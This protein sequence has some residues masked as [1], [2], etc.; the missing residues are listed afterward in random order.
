MTGCSQAPEDRCLPVCPYL[1]NHPRSLPSSG[2]ARTPRPLQRA[3]NEARRATGQDPLPEEDPN[4]PFFKSFADQRLRDPLDV[5]L[6]SVRRE[7]VAWVMRRWNGALLA[8]TPPTRVS[9]PA[10]SARLHRDSP[11]QAQINQYAGQVNKFAGQSF[12]KLFLAQSLRKA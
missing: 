3:E 4:L 1:A 8:A 9:H 2:P 6:M 11:M 7:G 12:G 10:P 5:L